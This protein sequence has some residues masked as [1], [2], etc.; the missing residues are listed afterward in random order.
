MPPKSYLVGTERNQ[1]EDACPYLGEPL[2]AGRIRQLRGVRQEVGLALDRLHLP[3]FSSHATGPTDTGPTATRAPP[4]RVPVPLPSCLLRLTKKLYCSDGAP[5]LPSRVVH[6]RY[7]LL[8]GGS[9]SG[10]SS[11]PLRSAYDTTRAATVNIRN[12]PCRYSQQTYPSC[13]CPK[14]PPQRRSLLLL[15][16]TLN[17]NQPPPQPWSLLTGGSEDTQGRGA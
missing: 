15:A 17:L 12:P 7:K 4:L 10:S 16:R 2:A 11:P 13:G 9:G 1:G 8:R 6:R 14:P 3:A 5:P